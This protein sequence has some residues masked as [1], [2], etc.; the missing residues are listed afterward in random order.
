MWDVFYVDKNINNFF[1]IDFQCE[2]NKFNIF[3]DDYIV[4]SSFDNLYSC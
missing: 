2:Y 4:Y 1:S 3:Y